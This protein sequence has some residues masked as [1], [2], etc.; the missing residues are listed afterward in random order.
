MVYARYNY[1]IGIIS[2]LINQLIT[3]GPHP[4]CTQAFVPI[5]SPGNALGLQWWELLRHPDG[6]A[7]ARQLL[8]ARRCELLHS[9]EGLAD[10]PPKL[11]MEV[12]MGKFMN[13]LVK[14]GNIYITLYNNI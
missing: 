10:F 6:S 8:A 12:R 3:G 11:F 4:V 5:D 13:I 1:N 9:Q 7:R 14:G 2:W